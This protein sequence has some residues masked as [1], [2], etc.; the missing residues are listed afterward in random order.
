MLRQLAPRWN[1]D[2]I[3]DRFWVS[4]VAG[5]L[6]ELFGVAAIYVCAGASVSQL[7]P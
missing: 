4:A 2:E 6:P 5:V 3:T 1:S 7:V